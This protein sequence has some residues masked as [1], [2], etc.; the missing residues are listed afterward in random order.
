VSALPP[1]SEKLLA[2]A[3]KDFVSE[4]RA[5]AARLRD[6]GKT[7][8]AEAVAALRKPSAVVFAVNRAARDRPKAA[9][10]AAAAAERLAKAQAGGDQEAFRAAVGELDAALDLLGEVA[11]AHVSAGGKPTDAMRRRVHDLLRRAV[12]HGETRAAL[13]RG[14][15]LEEQEAVGFAPF[16]GITA[17]TSRKR[18]R[19]KGARTETQ[20]R[21]RDAERRRR[22]REL[23]AE[24]SEAREA[25]KDAEKAARAAERSRARAEKDVETVQAKLDRLLDRGNM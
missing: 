11:V 1:E 23:R 16:E 8:D 13:E 6:A 14:A 12:G 22:E 9:R 17:P 25:L 4:R 7:E 3:P 20:S 24:L 15:L 2:V 21:R 19:A 5:L 18:S 10:D